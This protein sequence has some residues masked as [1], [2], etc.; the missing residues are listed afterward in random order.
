VTGSLY[1][2]NED[3]LVA[4]IRSPTGEDARPYI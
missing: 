2:N 4:Q 1:E 3:R